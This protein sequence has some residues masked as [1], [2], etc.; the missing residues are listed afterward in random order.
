M[1]ANKQRWLLVESWIETCYRGVKRGRAELWGQAGKLSIL[2]QKEKCEQNVHRHR[3]LDAA[4][5]DVGVIDR[6]L[7][8]GAEIND[9]SPG[10]PGGR[11][12]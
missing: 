6:M 1:G 11:R 9:P 4:V 7:S 12:C 10:M 2:D 3:A 8:G 5:F